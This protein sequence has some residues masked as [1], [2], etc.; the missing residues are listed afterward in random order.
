[1][2]Y[3]KLNQPIFVLLKKIEIMLD[4]RLETSMKLFT[5]VQRSIP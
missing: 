3:I 1:M 4:T 2:W 5:G